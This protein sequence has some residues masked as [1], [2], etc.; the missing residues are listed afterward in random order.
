[1]TGRIN[2]AWKTTM[3]AKFNGDEKALSAYMAARG[4][5]GGS[6]KTPKGFATMSREKRAAAGHLGGTNSKRT[7]KVVL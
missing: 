7:K 6:V 5:I 4:A 1:M 2:T 3:L